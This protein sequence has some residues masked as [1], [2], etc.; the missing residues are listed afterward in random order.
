MSDDP[1]IVDL[2]EPETGVWCDECKLPSRITF[3]A[4]LMDGSGV[5]GGP[6]GFTF[7]PDCAE[8]NGG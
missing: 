1:L 8:R 2:S 4:T 3:R 7:C 6:G 5:S